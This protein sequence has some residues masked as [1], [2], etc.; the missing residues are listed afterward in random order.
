V[1]DRLA[2]FFQDIC[3]PVAQPPF[4]Q[5]TLKFASLSRMA[6]VI[7]HSHA[8]MLVMSSITTVFPS[9]TVQ[10][11]CLSPIFGPF[12]DIEF[13]SKCTAA[14][15][16]AGFQTVCCNGDII[17]L[18]GQ[19]F[20]GRGSLSPLDVGNMRCCGL[21]GTYGW[22]NDPNPA[23]N[24]LR[25]FTTCSSGFPT[26]IFILAAT[27]TRNVAPYEITYTNLPTKLFSVS[28]M[29]VT[30]TPN[31]LWLYTASDVIMATVTV[32]YMQNVA[33]STSAVNSTTNH[34]TSSPTSLS[35]ANTF[36][37]STKSS[38]PRMRNGGRR[39]IPGLLVTCMS[40][41]WQL[42]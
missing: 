23:G 1:I 31:C 5:R 34:I 36:T 7:I 38:S 4:S 37:T 26:P 13:L 18:T 42:Y 39:L 25:Q 11:W 12:F 2:E 17:D 33:L 29:T 41:L 35:Q 24:A 9:G 15:V 30:G 27:N 20:H 16:S 21:P 10:H 22:R 28:D 6:F 32:P 40:L 14:N 3:T 19:A 8:R